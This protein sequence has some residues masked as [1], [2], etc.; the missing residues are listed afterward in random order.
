M[1]FGETSWL[2]TA[3]KYGIEVKSEHKSAFDLFAPLAMLH[4]QDAEVHIF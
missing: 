1:Q 2:N 4:G 3:D